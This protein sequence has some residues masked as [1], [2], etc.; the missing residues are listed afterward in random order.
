MAE[1]AAV[2]RG[3]DVTPEQAK[4][5][6]ELE[7]GREADQ[8]AVNDEFEA[9]KETD[10]KDGKT[11]DSK[12]EDPEDGAGE[13]AG[14]GDDGDDDGGQKDNQMIPRDRYN[15]RNEQFKNEQKLRQQGD[16]E[17]QQ[18]R[19][20][21]EAAGKQ[22]QDEQATDRD[23]RL[24]KAAEAHTKALEGDDPSKITAALK[25]LASIQA[26]M[27]QAS[28]KIP[29]AAPGKAYTR[30]DFLVE[31]GIA[32]AEKLYPVLDTDSDEF[33]QELVDEV[34]GLV[35]GFVA[36]G[37]T[38]DGALKEALA[39]SMFRAGIQPVGSTAAGSASDKATAAKKAAKQKPNISAAG[40]S[41]AV[42]DQPTINVDDLS[43]E[44]L[45]KLP[46][47]TVKILRGDIIE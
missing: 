7:A 2:D 42:G 18:L 22:E 14:A 9:N 29:E 1:A 25:D 37:M 44:E 45:A 32:E 11:F 39:F 46:Q 8:K 13:G 31:Q 28:I 3:D 40:V 16:F 41:G 33:D 47:S 27:V 26:E 10:E 24:T 30:E 6:E 23:A 21:L 17:N 5:S 19:A 36:S 12:E 43:A 34:D 4:Q 15:K 35:D 38:R 20:Q